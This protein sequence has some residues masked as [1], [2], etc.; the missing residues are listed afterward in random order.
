MKRENKVRDGARAEPRDALMKRKE[1]LD[2][3]LDHH[4]PGEQLSWWISA[5][6]FTVP[7]R[8]TRALSEIGPH[9][10]AFFSASQSLLRKHAWVREVVE[11]R[12]HPNYRRLNDAQ[13]TALP[14]LIRPDVVPDSD[15][16]PKLVELEITVGARADTQLMAFEYGLSEKG[17]LAR[18]Y[19]RALERRKLEDETTALLCASHEFF[20]DLPDDARAFASLLREQGAKVIV[21]GDAELPLLRV[22]DGVLVFED[23]AGKHRIKMIDRFL[24]IYEVAELVHPGIEAVLEAYL[25]G[26]LTDL[27][28]L[29]QAIDEK[30][31]MALFWHQDLEDEWRGLLGQESFEVLRRAIPVTHVLHP[32]LEV[33]VGGDRVPLRA[34]ADLPARDRQFVTKESGTSTTAS[35]AQSFRVL[36]E[37]SKKEL[38]RHLEELLSSGPPTV[39]QELI[40]SP[41]IEFT[42]LD[43]ETDK[44]HVQ[45]DARVK[46]SPFYVDGEL[47]ETRLVASNAKYAVNDERCVV[48]VVRR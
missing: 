48:S 40:E 44:I 38:R 25:G 39:L 2:R 41:K 36:H 4:N 24:D 13:P 15:W 20:Q 32:D 16:M 34:F 37:M 33:Q 21:I 17:S 27:N 35:G 28:T 7:K 43:P 5:E 1:N 14:G 6:P 47:T 12:F 22:E 31:W 8:M 46:L 9:L 26:G 3:R 30:A 23:D 19:V 45:T 29:C 11:K 18:S 42:A 10:T